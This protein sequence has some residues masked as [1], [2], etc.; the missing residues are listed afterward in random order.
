MR[1]A[2]NRI[3]QYGFAKT[4]MGEI[5]A[6]AGI[7]KGTAYLYFRS[8]AD[9][10][11]ALTEETNRRILDQLQAIAAEERPP[12]DRLHDLM[13]HRVHAIAE[14][15]H[16]YPHG[17][18]FFRSF[19]PEIVR[20]V[21]SYVRRQGELAASLIK[22]GNDI[23]DLAVADPDGTGAFLAQLFE[24][25]TP[26]YDHAPGEADVVPFAE[27]TFDLLLSGMRSHGNAGGATLSP[28]SP[29]S[30]SGAGAGEKP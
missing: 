18:E 13:L 1:A 24:R 25:F 28:S 16:K 23:G 12:V 11:L 29:S 10:M 2:W 4:T 22:Q 15:A 26:P 17:D 30:S 27:R 5:A 14:L 20:R 6:D 19:K 8:K 3:R 21:E 7:G 9:I